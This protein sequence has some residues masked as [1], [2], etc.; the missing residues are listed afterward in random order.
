MSQF[1]IDFILFSHEPRQ[2]PP[3]SK[4]M[5]AVLVL[6]L[7]LG[8]LARSQSCPPCATPQTP[9]YRQ[10]AGGSLVCGPEGE[11]STGSCPTGV[12]LCMFPT[13][14]PT[15]AP[16]VD[17]PT[18][19]PTEDPC[20]CDRYPDTYCPWALY[21][22]PGMRLC[23]AA[24]TPP[25]QSNGGFRI[26]CPT[27]WEE[28]AHVA[29]QFEGFPNPNRVVV[30]CG[31]GLGTFEGCNSRQDPGCL[32]EDRDRCDDVWLGSIAGSLEVV[33]VNNGSASDGTPFGLDRA[34][35][36]LTSVGAGT[37]NSYAL[38]LIATRNL[39]AVPAT[40]FPALE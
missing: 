13:D 16:T 24:V 7:E 38:K 25:W 29:G 22:S 6:L 36:L 4:T 40:A 19:A 9:C 18:A 5:P 31:A 14:P 2:P 1:P 8:S 12:S 21:H 15:A 26:A 17:P 32:R 27:D 39:V 34:F 28:C 37:I 33:G 3:P 11:G 30:D 35:P 23:S 20:A 10:L